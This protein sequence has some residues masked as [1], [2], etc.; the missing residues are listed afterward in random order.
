M[1]YQVQPA[2]NGAASHSAQAGPEKLF[3]TLE[4]SVFV[5]VVQLD[6]AVSIGSITLF[7]IPVW[8]VIRAKRVYVGLAQ[9]VATISRR[10][11]VAI[12]IGICHDFLFGS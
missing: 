2:D 9:I 8:F 4:I 11:C 12:F 5:V 7:W 6:D 3:R 10:A 1:N